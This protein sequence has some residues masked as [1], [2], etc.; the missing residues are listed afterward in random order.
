M[1]RNIKVRD[2]LNNQMGITNDRIGWDDAN[3]TV[4]V[5]NKAF[6]KPG[7]I[8]NGTSFA[9]S[10]ELSKAAD[11]YYKGQGMVGVRDYA[12]NTLGMSNVGWNRGKVTAGG[13][14]FYTPTVNVNG[15]TYGYAEDINRAAKELIDSNGYVPVRN[16]MKNK[17]F[18]TQHLEYDA[19]NKN[20]M[21]GEQ[22]IG[23]PALIMDGVSYMAPR[24]YNNMLNT[25]TADNV[26][27]ADYASSKGISNGVTFNNDGT[28]SFLGQNVPVEQ[29]KTD[30]NGKH[31]AMVNRSA[32]DEI[33][34]Q[35]A[36][37][38]PT[39]SGIYNDFNSRYGSRLDRALDKIENQ[40]DFEYNLEDDP[41]YQSYLEAAQRNAEKAYSDT[42]ARNAAMTGGFSN[43]NA[44]VAASQAR[45]AHLD[46]LN[47]RIPELY[48]AAYE[49]YNAERQREFDRLDSILNTADTTFNSGLMAA[50]YNAQLQNAAYEANEARRDGDWQ[51]VYQVGR[52]KVAD[53]RYDTE[54][55][56][57]QKQQ[58]IDNENVTR[59]LDLQEK[60]YNDSISLENLALLVSLA[61][62]GFTIDNAPWNLAYSYLREK[63]K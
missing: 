57:Q 30:G 10:T 63:L 22:N 33:Y 39:I 56:D 34:N 24:E 19:P 14:D 2:Y 52:D 38:N 37:S 11:D 45:D 5:D 36:A 7:K 29:I 26:M 32:M 8:D 48:R 27:A 6:Y 23:K 42:L 12:E 35:Y 3:K 60:Q 54:Y 46:T 62:A 41:Q 50:L 47:D 58:A 53:E 31:Y 13:K 43:S 51:D 16:D 4:T 61:T 1:D 49:R 18:T 59:Q 17:G 40:K 9:S 15:K 55:A 25:L 28:V 20:L 21:F 44:I